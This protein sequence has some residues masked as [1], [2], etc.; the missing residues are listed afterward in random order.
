MSPLKHCNNFAARMG[1]WSAR[2]WK[3]AIFG[4]LAFVVASVVHRRRGR[5]EVPRGLRPQRR[6]GQARPTSSSTP[7]SEPRDEQAEFVLIQSKTLKADDPA[8]QAAIE[9][10][11]EDARRLPAGA[12]ARV[13]ARRRPRRPVSDGRP[14]G[15]GRSSSPRHLRRG[16]ALHR[17]DRRRP[18]TKAQSRHPGLLRRQ[19]RQRQHRQGDRRGL[20]Q[21]A[22]DGRDDLDP[23][24][25][26]HPAARVR[27]RRRG[28]R[29]RCCSRSRPS[30]R[31]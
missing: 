27:L 28:A 8:F 19:S 7:A 20:Q 25:A 14:L 31:P 13:A 15:A 30:S 2:H 29:S 3:T 21:H 16:V 11:D 24:D 9:D 22:R 5:H 18:S 12:Q 23:A 26:D 10:V 17:R 6:R 4:W 1:R